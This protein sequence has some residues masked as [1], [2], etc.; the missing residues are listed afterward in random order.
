VANAV[1]AEDLPKV[2]KL[3]DDLMNGVKER[4]KAVE[5]K[6]KV[7]DGAPEVCPVIIKSSYTITVF[8]GSGCPPFSEPTLNSE[9]GSAEVRLEGGGV[10]GGDAGAGGTGRRR[11]DCPRKMLCFAFVFLLFGARGVPT[12]KKLLRLNIVLFAD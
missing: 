12:F 11:T 3:L 8:G 2:R 7:L 5:E 10:G 4:E 1:P 6:Q 9:E